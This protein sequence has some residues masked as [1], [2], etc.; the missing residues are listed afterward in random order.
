MALTYVRKGEPLE[1]AIQR[2]LQQAAQAGVRPRYLLPDRGFWSVNV[3]RHLQA[4]RYALLM[5][6]PCRGRKADHPKG[7][8]GTRVFH[9]RTKSGWGR[10][11]LTNDT[12]RRATGSI[13][14][15]CR[16]RRGERGQH[17]RG[18]LV[19]A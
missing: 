6:V 5:P 15:K 18:A 7:P 1:K 14:V 12:G 9:L 2:L 4:A 10:Y 8:G 19:Y 17:G 11:T 13:G 16:N 3:L